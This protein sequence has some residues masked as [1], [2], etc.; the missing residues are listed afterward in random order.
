MILMIYTY[1]SNIV[2]STKKLNKILNS[3]A[4]SDRCMSSIV[5]NVSRLN[6]MNPKKVKEEKE[7]EITNIEL[8]DIMTEDNGLSFEV[9]SEEIEDEEETK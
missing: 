9:I 6:N 3:V 4:P 8:S 2:E 5:M 7:I 1:N